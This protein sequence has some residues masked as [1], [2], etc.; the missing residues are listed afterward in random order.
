MKALK[1]IGATFVFVA[2]VAL[3]AQESPGDDTV[4][5]AETQAIEDAFAE[6]FEEPNSPRDRDEEPQDAGN[7]MRDGRVLEHRDATG[8]TYT[9]DIMAAVDMVGEWDNNEP[10]T[11]LNEFEVREVEVGFI[12]AVDHFAEGHV[13]MAAHQEGGEFLYEVH[14]AYFYFPRFFLPNTSAR[15]GQFFFDVGRLNSIHRH[16]WSFTNAPLVHEELLDEEGA[17]DTGL[18]LSF[19]MPWELFWQELTVGVFN[20]KE[21]GHTHVKGPTKN[22]PLYT[23][24]LKQ[25]VPFTAEWGSQF[26][27]SYL[28]W[29]PTEEPHKVTHQ[30]GGDLLLKWAGGRRSFQWLSEIWYRET[31]EKN[32]RRFDDPAT[33]IETRVGWYSF[34]EFRFHPQ[35]GA[36]YRYDLFTNPNYVNED[37]E[38]Q[39][40]NGT[41]AHSI[42]VTYYPS[43]F[44]YFR[45]TAER[46]TT[47]ETGKNNYQL[48]VQAD[49]II[50]AHPAHVY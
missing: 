31:R 29:H 33:P 22:N 17:V 46:A 41:E 35:W 43:E 9:L 26:G 7:F 1:F 49:F 8:N 3:Y 39:K 27:F 23:A 12:A 45:A 40:R 18:E 32:E 11:T 6:E 16:D 13:M 19:L 47:L 25:F 36:G 28:R 38:K 50:G 5:Q 21:F 48:Y 24:H 30:Y 10:K 14:E 42:M 2:G 15:L 44:S 20:G 34:L 37:G 4:A